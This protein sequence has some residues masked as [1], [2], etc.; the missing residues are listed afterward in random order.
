MARL[1]HDFLCT[2]EEDPH[3]FEAFVDK[4]KNPNPICPH[5]GELANWVLLSTPSIKLD[6]FSGDFPGAYE[7][8]NRKRAEKLSKERK[9][10][11]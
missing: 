11:A 10:N 4:E 1:M 9:Q 8:W 3:F 7:S 6:P 5:C 2:N